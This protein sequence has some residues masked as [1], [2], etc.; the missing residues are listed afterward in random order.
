[1]PI[2]D[3][4]I[5]DPS[6][7]CF[8]KPKMAPIAVRMRQSAP[9]PRLAQTY[10]VLSGVRADVKND[11]YLLRFQVLH[12]QAFPMSLGIGARYFQ[13]GAARDPSSAI[14]PMHRATLT[15]DYTRRSCCM[16]SN[17]PPQQQ[18]IEPLAALAVTRYHATNVDVAGSTYWRNRR[19]HGLARSS[20][21]TSSRHR[22]SSAQF[23]TTGRWTPHVFHRIAP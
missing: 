1:M 16:P 13:R 7:P 14:P 20:T 17:R 22:S 8:L 9:E 5:A 21:C 12:D 18:P 19:R 6:R 3:I 15:R 23:V 4:P 11:A 10:G 2:A